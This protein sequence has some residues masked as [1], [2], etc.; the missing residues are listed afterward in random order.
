MYYSLNGVLLHKAVSYVVVD[1]GGVGYRCAVSMNTLKQMPQVG[2]KVFIFTYLQ[3][4]EDAMD[5]FGF[6]DENEL[7]CFKLLLSVSGV[8]SKAAL[9][10]LSDLVPDRFAICVAAGDYK[11]LQKAQGIGAK[12]AQRIVLD[13]KDKVGS[14]SGSVELERMTA[15]METGSNVEE[16]VS[17]LMVLGYQRSDAAVIVS[18]LDPSLSVEELIRAGLKGLVT[19]N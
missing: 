2:D 9:S 6:N 4:R 1:C 16:A 17:A 15:N 19:K 8:G 13:L 3:V 5:L 12:L 10:I 7:N 11:A 18:K 14:F